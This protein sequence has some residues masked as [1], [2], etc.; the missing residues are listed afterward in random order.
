MTARIHSLDSLKGV[1]IFAVICL[2]VVQP[3]DAS[4]MSWPWQIWNQI[5]RFAVPCFF[6]T[7]G[8]F[9]MRAWRRTSD[10]AALLRAYA[11][12][13][14][15]PFFFWAL[16]YAVVPPFVSGAPRGIGAAIID[17]LTNIV[18][19][20][21]WFLMSGFVYHLWFLS[22]LLQGAV[23]VW[24]ALRFAN[25]SVALWLGGILYCV[26]LLGDPYSQTALGIQTPSPSF[27]MKA[28]PLVSTLFFAIGAWLADRGRN[29]SLAT[30]AILMGGGLV[31][32]L[33]EV[34][35]L[36][37]VF[38]RPI[39]S[40]NCVVGTVPYAVGMMLMALARPNIGGW[41]AEIGAYSLGIF[42]LHPYVI[43]VLRLLPFGPTLS[44]Y[45][46]L[47]AGLVLMITFLVIRRLSKI[48]W[49]RSFAV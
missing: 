47:F 5:C 33:A 7:A 12:R 39:V 43:E 28:G 17:H 8:F 24:L 38:G 9:F 30:G 18:R 49:F 10:H 3:A 45:P 14:M 23:L 6:L 20:P 1:G 42:T 13:L 44:D 41:A 26:A 21:H 25:L 16:F 19:Y 35:C 34:I 2:H 11:A 46:P 29:A 37:H 36:E 40:N 15:K 31:L 48:R 4:L 32:H 22:A 27:D